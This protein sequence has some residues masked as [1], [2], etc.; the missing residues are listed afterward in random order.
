MHD[1]DNALG[2]HVS[3]RAGEQWT[4]FGDKRMFEP[5]NGE[6]CKRMRACL[7]ASADEI[8]QSFD[9]KKIAV[10]NP[11][12]YAA[13]NH[14]PTLE[15]VFGTQNH[16]PLFTRD[17]QLRKN[18]DDSNDWNHGKLSWYDPWINVYRRI[19]GSKTMKKY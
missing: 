9:R 5:E 14:A 8:W 10:S 12:Q 13:W 2:L 17:G 6:N 3:N 11:D 4:A 16:S 7:Q 15:S 19:S 1:E 18:I